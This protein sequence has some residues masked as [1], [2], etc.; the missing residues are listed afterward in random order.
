MEALSLAIKQL[1][2]KQWNV[3]III[4]ANDAVVTCELF[5]IVLHV[6]FVSISPVEEEL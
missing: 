3:I 4:K 1:L 6:L 2:E 5:S